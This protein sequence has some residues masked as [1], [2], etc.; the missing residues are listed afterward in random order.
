LYKWLETIFLQTENEGLIYS[1][2]Q[3]P[4]EAYIGQTNFLKGKGKETKEEVGIFSQ[5]LLLPFAFAHIRYI[6]LSH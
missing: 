2:A 5:I 3:R 6:R 1:C 4:L